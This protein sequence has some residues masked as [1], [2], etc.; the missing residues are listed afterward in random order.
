MD[1]IVLSVWKKKENI[2]V[3]QK[4]F[5]KENGICPACHK[6]KLY[7]DEKQCILCREYHWEY[8]IKNPP[9]DQQKE[10]YRN[11]FRETQNKLY[12]ERVSKGICTRCGKLKVV[13]GRKKCG[14]CLEKDMILHRNRR[15]YEVE[16]QQTK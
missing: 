14:I 9:T 16:L 2:A 3:K 1:I 11:R 4:K 13:P 5:C 15:A 8:G 6:E 12:A 10:K 7:G